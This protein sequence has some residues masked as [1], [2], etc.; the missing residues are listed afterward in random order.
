MKANALGRYYLTSHKSVSID[1]E[2]EKDDVHIYRMANGTVVVQSPVPGLLSSVE[3]YSLSGGTI[4]SARL[5]GLLSW[6]WSVP[7]GITVVKVTTSDGRVITRKY[8][9]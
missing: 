5:D 2:Q 9:R 6:T 1:G 3:I 8:A 4:A 7:S